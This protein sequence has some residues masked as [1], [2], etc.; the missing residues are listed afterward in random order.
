MSQSPMAI[1]VH[2]DWCSL[3]LSLLGS[4]VAQ[5]RP[6]QPFQCF[7]A[8]VA[9]AA[10]HYNGCKGMIATDCNRSVNWFITVLNKVL[11]LISLKIN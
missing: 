10:K 9:T 5:I 6:V 11:A 4:C 1:S 8:V 2:C 7:A 3:S